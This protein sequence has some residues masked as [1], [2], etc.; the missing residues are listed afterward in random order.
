MRKRIKTVVAIAGIAGLLLSAPAAMASGREDARSGGKPGSVTKHG[1]CSAAS[2]WKLKLSPEDS[3]TQVEFEVDQN[4]S[5]DT[6][7]VA[8]RQNGH[9]VFHGDRVTKGASGSF[10]VHTKV[11]DPAGTDHYKAKAKNASTG[12]TCVGGA[13]I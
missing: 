7:H 4:K 6:W 1:S 8:I 9:R 12:E 5:G 3:K 13:S 11:A 2:T 10:T